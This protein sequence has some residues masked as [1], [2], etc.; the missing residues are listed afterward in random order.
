[1]EEKGWD[2]DF[3]MT[4]AYNRTRTAA[5]FRKLLGGELPTPAN[6]VYLQEDPERMYTTIRK[7]SKTCLAFKILA[8]GRVTNSAEQLDKAFHLALEN[9][10]PTDGVIVGMFPFIKDEIQENAE[11]VRRITAALT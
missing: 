7:T 10:K 8:A 5:E 2:L 9:I 3:F 1:V 4:C 11:R 6:E